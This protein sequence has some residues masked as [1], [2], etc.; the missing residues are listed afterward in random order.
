MSYVDST[1]IIPPNNTL[2]LIE[3]AESR[4]YQRK[5][6]GVIKSVILTKFQPVF[7]NNDNNSDD[8]DDEDVFYDVDRPVN[9]S[10]NLLMAL[11]IQVDN[12]T[13]KMDIDWKP[14]SQ[15][16][17][18][19]SARIIPSRIIPIRSN[20]AASIAFSDS[21]PG[22]RRRNDSY[23]E[24]KSNY[25]RDDEGKNN[26]DDEEEDDD[27]EDDDDDDDDWG[28]DDDDEDTEIRGSVA[29]S[30]SLMKALGMDI[31]GVDV[32]TDWKPPDFTGLHNSDRIIK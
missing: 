18:N 8:D 16:G 9:L 28:Y 25:D 14:P 1:Q 6:Q 11:G 13:K 31:S 20:S 3:F 23:N 17:L 12:T 29:M 21:G 24:S 19:N 15:Y 2:N 4:L 10:Q 30:A 22:D 26:E 32:S 5:Q 7:S 27:D